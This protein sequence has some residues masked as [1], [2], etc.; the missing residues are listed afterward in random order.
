MITPPAIDPVNPATI[1][2]ALENEGIFKT[3]DRGG[4]WTR[5]TNGLP[6]VGYFVGS[7][8]VDP[9]T[10]TTVYAGVAS[11][12]ASG[13]PGPAPPTG[14]YK[15][16]NAGD[17]WTFMSSVS[18]G[19]DIRIDPH[20]T[21]TIYSQ[22]DGVGPIKSIDG[23]STWAL[24]TNG[25]PSKLGVST[26]AIDPEHPST[27]YLGGGTS[28]YKSDDG[29][30]NWRQV[31]DQSAARSLAVDPTNSSI[32]Y[33]LL[34]IEDSAASGDHH[35]NPKRHIASAD[36][37]LAAVIKSVDAGTDWS[38]AVQGIPNLP[39][40]YRLAI[41]PLSTSTVYVGTAAGV[42]RTTDGGQNWKLISTLGP[43]DA[44]GVLPDPKT[45]GIIYVGGAMVDLPS[46][47]L[48]ADKISPDGSTLSYSKTISG[49]HAERGSG[50]V[51]D[52]TGNAYL[53]GVTDSSDFP[54]V[55]AFQSKLTGGSNAVIVKLDATG[56]IAFS[57]FLGGS[58]SEGG[59]SI[60][61]DAAGDI[62]VTGSTF[63]P[64]FPLVSPVQAKFPPGHNGLTPY[65]AFI[66]K[67]SAPG[68]APKVVS[69]Q[70]QGKSLWVYGSGFAQGAVIIAS[71]NQLNT[72]N[73]GQ[74]PDTTLMSKKGGK[75]IKP[76]E[77]A[78]IQVMN[79]D[80]TMS[81][82]ISFTPGN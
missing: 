63:S 64:D 62:Y 3:I 46:G 18:D 34:A 30:N 31:E 4:H 25:L 11:V 71:G 41:D 12:V 24:I 49:N 61:V 82:T 56:Q 38:S 80:G 44:F 50:I 77:A 2:A 72:I 78:S 68:A 16:T 58:Q 65:S 36:P 70:K 79:P 21:S 48:F 10:P 13:L 76:G 75:K 60:A 27:L 7:I 69:A 47:H 29:G 15:S 57:S 20:N 67:I 74:N 14:V 54:T 81:N 52:S 53:T 39:A 45:E 32:V 26:I 35:G 6:A 55:G 37:P 42:Y 59:S 43:A 51:V 73:D 66:T 33:A 1:Y 9:A 22:K 19:F 5:L 8:A 40:L 23:G 28:I 17:S